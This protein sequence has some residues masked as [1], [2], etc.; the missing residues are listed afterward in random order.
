[1]S[2]ELVARP[3]AGEDAV[4]RLKDITRVYVSGDT[5]TIALKSVSLEIFSG[6]FVAIVG[7]S[8]SGKSTMMNVLGCLDRPTSGTYELAGTEVGHRSAALR[9]VARNRLIGFVFQGYNLLPRLTA[10]ENTELP[11][12]YRSVPRLE[13]K[14]RAKAALEQ[15][16]LGHRL[17]HRPNEMSGGQQ[18]RVA[19]ARALV[20]DPPLLLADEPTGNLDTRTTLEVLAMLQSLNRSRGLTIVLVTHE[21][22][23]AACAR[24][25]VT[26]RDGLIVSDLA[27]EV[28]KDA[29][30]E[31]SRLPPAPEPPKPD[32]AKTSRA[33]ALP[34]GLYVWM[35]LGTVGGAALGYWYCQ[36]FFHDHTLFGAIVGALVAETMLV[37]TRRK[38]PITPDERWRLALVATGVVSLAAVVTIW[39]APDLLADIMTPLQATMG[40]RGLPTV[41]NA[42][43]L[44]ALVALS[45]SRY[46]LLTF[47]QNHLN[48]F[49]LAVGAA[50]VMTVLLLGSSAIAAI[51]SWRSRPPASTMNTGGPLPSA[52]PP[53][54][55]GR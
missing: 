24:R 52:N 49:R 41:S 34:R 18:Q 12:Q 20:T 46:A 22:E 27:N 8:G 37:S 25:V 9:A 38:Q 30:D 28:Q 42:L 48:R 1:M 15:V 43:V 13:R 21:P 10:Q 32:Q 6:D 31:L 55:T 33:G 29:A 17:D 3:N 11:L 5:Q 7:T 23:V 19:I 26:L 14:A 54:R 45:G 35:M 4:I 44:T 36:W 40:R 53:G 39:A 47:L 50:M 16:G 2:R 51:K